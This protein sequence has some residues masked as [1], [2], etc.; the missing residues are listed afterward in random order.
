MEKQLA[1]YRERKNKERRAQQTITSSLLG[2]FRG[3]K[4]NSKN[5]Q[6]KDVSST[7][8]SSMT[9]GH[10]KTKTNVSHIQ[11]GQ[12]IYHETEEE[13]IERSKWKIFNLQNGLLFLLWL[14]LWKIFIELEFGAVYFLVT[15]FM[16]IYFNTRTGPRGNRLS[17]YSVFN[18]NFERLEG[19]LTAEQFEQQVLQRPP[20]VD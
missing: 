11:G 19:T 13:I 12:V 18:P 4:T 5:D 2:L 20:K 7:T 1:E 17:A 3:A 6:S 10:V 8:S 16:F 15:G 9:K 14:L